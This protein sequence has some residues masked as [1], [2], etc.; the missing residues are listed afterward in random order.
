MAGRPNK[1]GLD[2][3][4]LDCLLDDNIK[5]IQAEFGLKGFA[6]IVKLYQKIYGG[7]GYY[8]E[9]NE[10]V[11]LL[12][13]VENGLSSDNKNLIN[14]IVMACIRRG[15][16]SGKLFNKFNIL[17]SSGVQKRYLNAASKREK[18]ELKKEYLLISVGKN[19]KNA[20]I[21]SISDIRKSNNESENTQSRE[22]ESREGITVSKD[23]VRQTEVRRAVDA[24]NQMEPC[25]IAKVSKLNASSQRY[26]MLS[27]RIS[28]YGIDDVLKAID[29]VAH[30]R[31]LQG[32]IG[33]SR[34]W[35]IT[36][37]WFV[38]PNNF[39]KVLDGNYDDKKSNY[40]DGGQPGN[41]VPWQ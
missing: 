18:V 31:F 36:F 37:D 8:C 22:E 28:E 6:V 4:E 32:K 17:T 11:L 3:F 35:I 34:Q 16:F 9:W 5:L 27:A 1:V 14:E 21:N 26:K 12:F 40:D 30:S 23:T 2:Y 29:K 10:D 7:N 13:L 41:Y 38:R 19:H 15:I 20:V 25:G 39:P 24:W 33:G